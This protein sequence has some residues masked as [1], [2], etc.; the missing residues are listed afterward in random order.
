MTLFAA[1]V[2]IEKYGKQEEMIDFTKKT[3]TDL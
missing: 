1:L 2:N 3:N